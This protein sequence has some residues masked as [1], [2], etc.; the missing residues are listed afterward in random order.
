MKFPYLLLGLL[1]LVPVALAEGLPDLGDYAQ[2][3]LPPQEERRI[4]EEI[5]RDIR[6]SGEL[7]N[8]VEVAD[9]LGGLG[10]R[11]AAN[12]SDNRQ[13]FTFFVIQDPTI[14]AFA[15]PGGFIGVHTGLIQSA[16]SESE[17][18]SVVAHEIGHVVQRHLARMVAQQKQDTIPSIAAMALAILMARANP[19]LAQA[20]L[21]AVQAGTVQRQ[22]NYTRENEREADRVGLQIL[23]DSGFDTRAM[24]SFFETLMKGTRFYDGSA[25]SF[26]RTHPLTTERIADVRNRVEQLPYHQVSDS[27]EFH[28]VRARLR[29]MQGTPADAVQFF[30]SGLRDG[31][32]SS[33]AAQHYG[34]AQALMRGHEFDAAQREV[35]MLRNTQQRHPMIESLAAQ[36]QLNQNRNTEAL[37]TFRSGLALFPKHRGLIYGYAETLISLNQTDEA[38]RF[39][40]DK[41]LAFPNDGYLYELQSQAYTQQGKNLLRHQAQGEA[42]YRSYDLAGAIEQM[43]LAVKSGEGDFYQLSIVEARLKQL[44]QLMVDPKDKK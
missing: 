21:A 1:L 28:L 23:N 7:V 3:V 44:R 8:D 6:G 39:L 36:L 33:E 34:L 13:T 17:L 20:G 31:K 43:E 19:E 22:L 29:A 5:M 37:S 42:Y 40:S 2:T 27:V 16:R 35:D 30:E 15:L 10:Y 18:A 9:Y 25:P 32:F 38:V 24:P 26:L 12:S 4:G 11:L 41:Q 14:N